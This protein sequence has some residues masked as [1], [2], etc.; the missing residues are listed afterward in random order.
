MLVL[1]STM[2]LLGRMDE[3]KPEN[4]PWSAYVERLEQFFEAKDI[5]AGKQVATL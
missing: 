1:V 4:E 2:G 5:A 3:F